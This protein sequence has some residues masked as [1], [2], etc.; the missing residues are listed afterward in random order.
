MVKLAVSNGVE[1]VR[2]FLYR[3]VKNTH[4]P[5]TYTYTKSERARFYWGVFTLRENMIANIRNPSSRV[6]T[7]TTTTTTTL[8]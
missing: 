7:T 6:A 5:L 1:E 2:L 8:I 4:A 3:R